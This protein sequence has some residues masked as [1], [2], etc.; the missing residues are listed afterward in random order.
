[1]KPASTYLFAIVLASS[2]HAGLI[3]DPLSNQAPAPIPAPLGNAPKTA[4]FRATAP[5]SAPSPTP[6]ASTKPKATID[7]ARAQQW[8][9]DL[10]ASQREGDALLLPDLMMIPEVF[11]ALH[12]TGSDADGLRGY[13]EWL[14][15]TGVVK[16]NILPG[17]G[18]GTAKP[19]VPV[20]GFVFGEV[21]YLAGDSQ[22]H[23]PDVAND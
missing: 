9:D 6:L 19:H 1:M 3:T 4:A 15:M 17:S 7:F 2:A 16:G 11:E 12:A 10:I 5:T 13:M 20:N 8:I 18:S 14:L 22:D 21:V 23:N